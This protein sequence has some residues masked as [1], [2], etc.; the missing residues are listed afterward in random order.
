MPIGGTPWFGFRESQRQTD[1]LDVRRMRSGS[2]V[3][4]LEQWNWLH[5]LRNRFELAIEVLDFDLQ[6]VLDP[7]T[8]V[9]SAA[10]LRAAMQTG[11]E[12]TLR[13]NATAV[14]RT[15]KARSLTAGGL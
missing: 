6:Y 1:L 9:R 4:R 14:L 7:V 10:A 2:L 11:G 3:A 12:G 8:H 5:E 15:A 13:D